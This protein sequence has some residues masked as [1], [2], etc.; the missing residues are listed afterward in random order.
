MAVFIVVCAT[1]SQGIQSR[2]VNREAV[3]SGLLDE[4]CV[5][6]E[7][8]E[9]PEGYTMSESYKALCTDFYVN[10]KLQVKMELPKG[11]ETIL[12]LFERVRKQFPHMSN[13]RRYRDELA[14]ESTPGEMP[15]RWMAIKGT[16]L[17]TGVVNAGSID[18]ASALHRFILE[19]APSFLSISALDVDSLEL[20]F[21]FDLIA[22]GN[23]NQIVLD[24]LLAGS[25]LH[26]LVDIPDATIANFQPG[27]GLSLGNNKDVEV[28]FEVKTHATEHRARDPETSGTGEPISVYV[29][30][31]KL[32]PF[33]EVKDLPAVFQRLN[34]L[35]QELVEDRVIPGVVLPLH[36][37]IRTGG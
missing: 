2:V 7:A 27:V 26:S 22:T 35:G 31:R 29:T 18:D 37:V 13:F 6:A 11:R 16:H 8:Q 12:D 36:E 20:L 4:R 23:H 24:A 3:P 17:R 21:G 34:K 9:A 25:P 28:F 33:T 1:W 30:L 19:V 32:G 10:Q 14:L 15:H 5:G